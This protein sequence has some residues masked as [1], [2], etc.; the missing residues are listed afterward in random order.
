MKLIIV[1]L[2]VLIFSL[3]AF[4]A[5]NFE[6]NYDAPNFLDSEHYDPSS[7]EVESI[8]QSYDEFYYQETGES[9]W[10]EGAE[11]NELFTPIGGCYRSSCTVYVRISKRTQSGQLFIHGEKRLE[12]LVST[13][14]VTKKRSYRTPNFDKHPNG[15]I[16]NKYSSSKY[17]GGDYNGL[18]NMPYA[19]FIRG[20]YALHGTPRSNWKKLGRRASHGCI[21]MHPDNAK[22]V[23]RWVRRAGIKQ[24]W[25]TVY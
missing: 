1:S 25:I 20:G 24:T 6:E 13:G 21:R 15:R 2:S 22:I 5:D 19:I 18:G 4:S 16:Y 17:P 10:L 8:L 7:P 12:F 9:P 14:L 3:H 11:E 23:N